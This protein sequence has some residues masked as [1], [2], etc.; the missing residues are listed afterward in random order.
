MA[1]TVFVDLIGPP[2]NA[3]WLND[4]NN[5]VYGGGGG[6]IS[7]SL[8]DYL[9]AGSGAADTTVQAKLRQVVSILDFGADPTGVVPCDTA[10]ANACAYI[11]SNHAQLVF[12]AGTYTYS[13]SPNW[14]ISF[15]DITT[16]GL[17]T[18]NYIGTGYAVLIDAGATAAVGYVYGMSFVGN[19]QVKSNALAKD[20]VFV[21]SVH[22][23]KI[24]LRVTGCGLTYAGVRIN[25]SV[26]TEYDIVVSGGEPNF[27][28]AATPFYGIYCDQR[29]PSEQTAACIFNNPI[30]EGVN[31]T[32]IYLQ[33][34]VQNTFNS[35]TSEGNIGLGL[36]V[37]S[38]CAFNT[39]NKLDL[40]VN[41]VAT[42]DI[43]DN[44][45]ATTFNG[46]LSGGAA[47]TKVTFAG[48]N[49]IISGGTYNYIYNTG[50]GTNLNNVT[51]ANNGGIFSNTGTKT[52][53]TRLYNNTLGTYD[54]DIKPTS[55]GPTITSAADSTATTIL[56]L[57][58]IGSN[59]YQVLVYL[60]LAGDT[61]NYSAYAV[62]SQDLTSTRIMSQ[63]NGTRM[64]LSLVGQAI[65][66]TQ[67]SG[68][69]QNITAI[70]NAI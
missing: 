59:F 21:R 15:A 8:V 19:F 25:F 46:C 38:N 36:Y 22:H 3:A 4:V 5:A 48:T 49:A 55:I 63:V 37:S 50:S 68:I 13:T 54:A 10:L 24:T 26:C 12:P 7:S 43:S 58:T 62:V 18:L 57:P 64:V 17:V 69:T 6:N 52:S 51:Y 66:A 9:P 30:I 29:G 60:P 27:V 35:G 33:N 41:G 70:A 1:S 61:A 67:T 34:A 42:G 28:Y 45:L 31:G 11:T 2:V 40:E 14:G 16:S 32:G 39:F 23:S 65:K 56:T 44:G 20:A 47:T 53:S